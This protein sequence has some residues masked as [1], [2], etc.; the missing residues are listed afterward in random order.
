MP[1]TPL[2]QSAEDQVMDQLQAEDDAALEALA[3][4]AGPP[5]DTKRLS[6][7]E[8]DDLY[9]FEDRLVGSDPDGFAQRLATEGIPPEIMQRMP[10]FKVRPDWLPLYQQPTQDLEVAQQ[11]MKA[12]RWPFRWGLFDDVP[13]PTARAEKAERLDRRFQKRHTAMQEQLAQTIVTP[14]AHQGLWKPDGNEGMQ[15]T[16]TSPA[17]DVSVRVPMPG[18]PMAPETGG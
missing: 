8:E 17:Q 7:S 18:Q 2:P 15:N 4:Q 3:A 14:S 1:R 6:E 9:A 12:A 13:E 10:I 16:F 11:R 5:P